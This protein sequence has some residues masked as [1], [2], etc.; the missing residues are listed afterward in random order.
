[1]K[2]VSSVKFQC[3]R[4]PQKL[5][6]SLRVEYDLLLDAAADFKNAICPAFFDAEADGLKQPWCLPLGGGVWINP[7]Y[8]NCEVW[9]AKAYLE[10]Y[11]LRNCD[12]AVLLLP[13]AVGVKWFSAALDVAECHLFDE[14]IRFELPPKAELP[15]ELRAKLYD[16]DKPKSSPGGGNALF[17]FDRESGLTGVTGLR[18]SKTGRFVRDFIT[19]EVFTP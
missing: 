10:V 4:T 6:D 5:A 16:G 11:T 12:R 1:M 8:Q 19:G 17:I 14:R 3:W 2:H 13:A 9:L 15:E 7:P 18:S